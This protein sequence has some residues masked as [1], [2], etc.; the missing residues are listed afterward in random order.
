M[1]QQLFRDAKYFYNR[2]PQR[3]AGMQDKAAKYQRPWISSSPVRGAG[4]G[5]RERR[6]FAKILWTPQDEQN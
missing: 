6:G 3:W 4:K 5:A 1:T 2:A